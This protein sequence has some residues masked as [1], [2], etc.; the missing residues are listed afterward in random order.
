MV[1]HFQYM[2]T[3]QP[4]RRMD[5]M[6]DRRQ[7]NAFRFAPC[8]RLVQKSETWLNIG[9]PYTKTEICLPRPPR[10]PWSW[11]LRWPSFDRSSAE[12][13]TASVCTHRQWGISPVLRGT[14]EPRHPDNQYT[15]FTTQPS[16]S[17]QF[18]TRF[19]WHSSMQRSGRPYKYLISM[20][21]KY[22]LELF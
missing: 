10:V 7:I 5:E 17:S 22:T 1:S 2:V 16:N 20:T 8:M 19:E 3:R 14:A 6:T 11:W 12:T 4:E 21:V 15:D 18:N 13:R 9:Q